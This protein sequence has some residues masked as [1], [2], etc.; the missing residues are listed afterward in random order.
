MS[1]AQS[2]SYANASRWIIPYRAAPLDLAAR[3]GN[4]RPVTVEIGFGMGTASAEIAA[5]NTDRNY[6]GIEV[7]RAGIGRLIWEIEKRSL[8]NIRIIEHDAAEVV[9]KLL[10]PESIAA[11]HIFFPDP[12][13]KKK[14]HKRRLLQKPF[15]ETL[16]SR[17]APGGY[18]YVVSDCEDY[19]FA[20][21]EALG[22][23][24]TLENPWR[25]FAPA[26]AWRPKTKFETKGIAKNHAINE[27][28][29]VRG[30]RRNGR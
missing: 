12:W 15:A 11:F 19:A 7:F 27:I 17:L 18:V 21:L 14:H 23:V 5:A 24:E 8:E 25:G 1:R 9:E 20:A 10:V 13:P 16:A 26:Q 3:F 29:F 2:R 4:D 6:L 30:G 22:G 28:Y